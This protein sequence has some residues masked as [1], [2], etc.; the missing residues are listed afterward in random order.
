MKTFFLIIIFFSSNFFFGFGFCLLC[1]WLAIYKQIIIFSHLPKTSW[2]RIFSWK[3]GNEEMSRVKNEFFIKN[4]KEPFQQ[5][6]SIE[7]DENEKIKFSH[8]FSFSNNF[9]LRNQHF[10]RARE[11]SW[12]SSICTMCEIVKNDLNDIYYICDVK[13]KK[14]ISSS[15]KDVNIPQL[16]FLLVVITIFI[17]FFHSHS[18]SLSSQR[19]ADDEMLSTFL[20]LRLE[21][22]NSEVIKKSWKMNLSLYK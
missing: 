4:W 2:N 3:R 21:L 13:T 10:E 12:T 11:T 7:D 19:T 5:E 14:K 1:C 9:L 20:R 8:F 17:N 22:K 18:I 6:K 15:E 16:L